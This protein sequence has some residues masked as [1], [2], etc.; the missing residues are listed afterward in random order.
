MGNKNNNSNDIELHNKMALAYITSSVATPLLEAIEIHRNVY[1]NKELS[2][3]DLLNKVIQSTSNVLDKLEESKVTNI[4]ELNNRVMLTISVA[5]RNNIVLYNSTDVSL[6]EEQ[7]TNMLSSTDSLSIIKPD[8]GLFR[9]ECLV[10]IFSPFINFHTGL[11]FSGI[12]DEETMIKL[13]AMSS[14]FVSHFFFDILQQIN[15]QQGKSQHPLCNEFLLTQVFKG[16]VVELLRE[17]RDGEVDPLVY[18]KKTE[19]FFDIL[20]KRIILNFSQL[21]KVIREIG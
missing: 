10:E 6:I 11:F 7:I 19:D 5:L 4:S 1:S 17:L 12:I 20:K 16:V 2:L 8:S 15:N 21:N 14:K 18:T 13:N 3:N 9:V